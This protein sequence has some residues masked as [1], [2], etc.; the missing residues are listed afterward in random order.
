MNSG[1]RATFGIMFSVTN[2]GS[3][4][5]LTRGDQVKTTASATP[6]KAPSVNPPRISAAVTARLESQAY[7][8]DASVASVASGEGRMNF[9]TWKASTNTCQSTIM[10]RC[11]IRMIASDRAD[12]P[13]S[14]GTIGSSLV[15]C[16]LLAPCR[17]CQ[18]VAPGR[19][20]SRPRPSFNH[21]V[22]CV[23]WPQRMQ[24]QI[25]HMLAAR[26]SGGRA[27]E[28]LAEDRRQCRVVREVKVAQSGDRDI[29]MHRVDALS[30][31]AVAH[32]FA[33]DLGDHGDQWR[34]Q[35]FDPFGAAHMRRAAAV[36]V[37]Q[38]DDE[39]GVLGEVVERAFD[40]L[41]NG[42]LRW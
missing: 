25:G 21:P 6:I 12:R 38:Q 10:A 5:R 30:E 37:V 40:E 8:A 17:F 34:M 11:T 1:P 41:P 26:A 27:A 28:V 9:G 4:K 39:I 13:V 2:S 16:F 15:S 3:S 36:L 32:A 22:D 18:R 14:P 7:L 29:E 42:L 31:D 24:D 19:T 33:E 23:S 35:G 20:L